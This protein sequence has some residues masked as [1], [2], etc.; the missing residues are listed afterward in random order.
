[1]HMPIF[2]RLEL[3]VPQTGSASTCFYQHQPR[4]FAMSRLLGVTFAV[5]FC[6]G[7]LSHEANATG[8]PLPVVAN[9]DVS[10]IYGQYYE[11]A[12]YPQWYSNN[13]TNTAIAFGP[14]TRRGTTSV[15]MSCDR[16]IF[17]PKVT[18]FAVPLSRSV[19]ARMWANLRPPVGGAFSQEFDVMM[20]ARD[21]SYFVI[22]HPSRKHL[23]ILNK[24]PTMTYA[25][26]N[27]IFSRLEAFY[28]YTNVRRNATCTQHGDYSNASCQSALVAHSMVDDFSEIFNHANPPD[29][30]ENAQDASDEAEVTLR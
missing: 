6:S 27:Y 26:L 12:S 16:G 15:L 18:G 2:N 22:G 4:G 8:K 3:S 23:F 25:N 7:V 11:I 9:F 14:T 24:H 30:C 29:F 28:S 17:R 20:A 19:P 1:M 21:F 5:A 13:C 10:S